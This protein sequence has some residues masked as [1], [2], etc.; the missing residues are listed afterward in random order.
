MPHD[1]FRTE[2]LDPMET[3]GRTVPSPIFCR[4]WSEQEQYERL[5]KF[6]RVIVF[7]SVFNKTFG[8]LRLIVRKGNLVLHKEIK[9]IGFFYK[10]CFSF[11]DTPLGGVL[12]KLDQI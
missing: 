3:A 10:F 4:D 7:R 1:V 11:L 6:F 12:H 8:L 2:W 9:E 5:V